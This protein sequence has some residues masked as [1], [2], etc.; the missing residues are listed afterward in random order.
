MRFQEAVHKLNVHISLILFFALANGVATVF[1]P[2]STQ[3]ES[4]VVATVFTNGTLWV[5]VGLILNLPSKYSLSLFQQ[6]QLYAFTIVVPAVLF[7]LQ[8]YLL[9]S[10]AKDL[11]DS[12]IYASVYSPNWAGLERKSWPT[13]LIWTFVA[14]IGYA[15]MHLSGYEDTTLSDNGSEYTYHRDWVVARKFY[16]S[17]ALCFYFQGVL[18]GVIKAISLNYT[19][20]YPVLMWVTNDNVL[21]QIG[22]T[23]LLQFFAGII[24]VVMTPVVDLSSLANRVLQIKDINFSSYSIYFPLRSSV[25]EFRTSNKTL[26]AGYKAQATDQETFE[27]MSSGGPRRRIPVFDPVLVRSAGRLSSEIYSDFVT[28]TECEQLMSEDQPT[29]KLRA[30]WYLKNKARLVDPRDPISKLNWLKGAK[31]VQFVTDGCDKD[32]CA[33]LFEHHQVSRFDSV[34]VKQMF[35]YIEAQQPLKRPSQTSIVAKWII[36]YT[37]IIRWRRG[38]SKRWESSAVGTLSVYIKGFRSYQ[39]CCTTKLSLKLGFTQWKHA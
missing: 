24:S 38:S 16:W 20:W 10:Y 26:D 7:I 17:V 31:L 9:L 8:T 23:F 3:W 29:S 19:H 39:I 32:G 13:Y 30:Q 15:L 22:P 6:C 1:V 21:L 18:I 4:K 5:T 25:A 37:S 34:S 27:L 35:A 36:H 33:S 12:A 28:D 11:W 14:M 2:F